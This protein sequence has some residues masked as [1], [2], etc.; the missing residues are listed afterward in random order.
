MKRKLTGWSLI[1]DL[2][3]AVVIVLIFAL[4]KTIWGW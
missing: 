3:L 4:V 1:V 2:S